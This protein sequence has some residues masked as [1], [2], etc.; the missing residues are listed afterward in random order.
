MQT[1]DNN[2]ITSVEY[3]IFH[4]KTLQLPAELSH[5][6]SPRDC[7]EEEEIDPDEMDD[8]PATEDDDTPKPMTSCVSAYN[9]DVTQP[10]D[11]PLLPKSPTAGS[12]FLMSRRDKPRSS[13]PVS[14]IKGGRRSPALDDDV[15]SLFIA[16]V[17][18]TASTEL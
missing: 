11:T 9:D 8:D 4:S 13:P 12:H 2:M 1:S 6:G 15:I 14:L 18:E 3:L 5:R 16:T 17:A 10:F 7:A